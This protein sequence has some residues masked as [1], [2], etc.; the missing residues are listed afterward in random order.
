M[1]YFV[2]HLKYTEH[3][4]ESLAILLGHEKKLDESKISVSLTN[5][6]FPVDLF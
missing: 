2:S 1:Y 5:Y 4:L 3:Q 6:F